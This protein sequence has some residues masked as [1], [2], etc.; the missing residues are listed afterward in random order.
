M[1]EERERVEVVD[2]ERGK[3][4]DRWWIFVYKLMLMV[5]YY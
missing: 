5:R 2:D 3:D 4:W 1:M